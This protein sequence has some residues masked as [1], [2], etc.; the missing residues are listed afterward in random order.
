MKGLYG[1][2]TQRALAVC[3][4][5][6]KNK[7][8]DVARI[9]DLFLELAANGPE[10]Y[11]GAFRHVEGGF[12]QTVESFPG[13][14]PLIPSNLNHAGCSYPSLGI[15]IALFHQTDSPEMMRQ[16]LDTGLLLTRNPMEVIGTALTG[17]LV[18]CFLSLEPKEDGEGLAKEPSRQLLEDAVNACESGELILK[19]RFPEIEEASGEKVYQALRLT[20]QG[21]LERLDWE[22][23]PLFEWIC[24]NASAHGQNK[25]TRPAQGHVL[26]LLPL[27]LVM[28]LKGGNDFAS[29]LTRSLNM[30]KESARLGTLVGAWAGALYGFE[31]IPQHWRTSLV[32]SREIRAKGESL[33]KR[34][35]VKGLKNFVDMEL[36]LTKKEFEEGKKFSPKTTQKPSRKI[37]SGFD[38]DGEELEESVIPK[39]EDTALWRKFQK[40]KTKMKRDRRRN[41]KLD[42][43]PDEG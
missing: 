22:S 13:R 39:K 10:N 32:N 24:E 6:L 43:E 2:Q 31:G 27:A 11:Y 1:A 18:T 29:V 16:C 3:D 21:T 5:V 38:L 15:P 40:D 9:A 34:R 33:F 42:F 25:I 4:C 12:Y 8:A 37:S 17:Y 26:T 30:G 35:A 7:K 36:A 28:V 19:Q 23:G 14:D 41:L 20:V